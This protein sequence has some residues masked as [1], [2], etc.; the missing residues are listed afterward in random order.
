METNVVDKKLFDAI[1]NLR[2]VPKTSSLLISGDPQAI[3]Q[4]ED[5]LKKFD[6]P[7]I[8][9]SE[10]PADALF[11]QA[12][13]FLV[14]KLQY[15]RG[16][17]IQNAI[18]KIGA[19]LL[20]TPEGAKEPLTEAIT[21]MQWIEVTNSLLASGDA[22]SLQKIKHLIENLD[23]PLKQVLI[24]V[25]VIETTLINSQNFGL[26]WIAQ[27]QY[28]SRL[29]AV[30][31]NTNDP[32]T[33]LTPGFRTVVPTVGPTPGNLPIIGGFDLGVIGNMLFHRGKSFATIGSLVT[34]LQNDSDSTIVINPKIVTIMRM[35]KF[36]G[37]Q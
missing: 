34:A 33:G 22:E 24:E 26:E 16:D 8:A 23:I 28:K 5:L 4:I 18:K 17:E 7:S 32:T 15:Q 13:N 3:K 10:S 12:T 37:A 9:S 29:A 1:D 6:V 27:G 11:T 36:A 35:G 25:L 21:S 31:S 19:S 20:A 2:W 30:T 14:F